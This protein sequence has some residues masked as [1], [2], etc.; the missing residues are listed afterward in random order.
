MPSNWCYVSTKC[1]QKI[2]K[3]QLR[4]SA[5]WV[6]IYP[7]KT[8][9]ATAWQNQ[10]IDLCA[11][12]TLRSAWACAVFAGCLKK[13]WVLSYPMSAQRRLWLDCTDAPAD[14]CVRWAHMSFRW[15]CHALA[16]IFLPQSVR[17]SEY[18]KV[19]CKDY[20]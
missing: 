6:I 3:H 14:L 7:C 12:R 16:Q 10:Q 18:R 4:S 11:Q 8:K 19:C 13:A 15:F 9:W 2:E 1:Y 5:I 20:N 17:E